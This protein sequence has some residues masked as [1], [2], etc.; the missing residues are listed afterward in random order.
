MARRAFLRATVGVLVARAAGAQPARQGVVRLVLGFAAGGAAD[1]VARVLAPELARLTGR[2]A[3][4]EN[5]P[6][7]NSGRAIQRVALSEPDGDTLLFATS[8][9]AHPDH[10]AAMEALRPVVLASTTPMVLVVRGTLPVHDAKEFARWLLA[11]P[12]ATYGS[13][14]IGNAT[15]LC[16]AELVERL[17]ATA[18][19]VPYSGTT[20][21]FGD[22]MGGHIDF[23]VMGASPS[24]A[25]QHA[26]RMLAVTTRQRSRLPGLDGLPTVADLLGSDFDHSL[27]QAVYAPARVPVATRAALEAPFREILMLDAVRV[28]LADVGSEPIAGGPDAADRA[29]AA[30]AARYAAR[31]VR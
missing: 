24:L 20:P 26:V 6:G 15:H 28:A 14:G 10:A 8:A 30:E 13:A 27:W 23:L 29:F 7:A 11:H 12:G 22:L 17:G 21:A 5:V 18:T 9:I 4:V 19:H 2:S 1:R 31:T 3:I 16:A 25:Q